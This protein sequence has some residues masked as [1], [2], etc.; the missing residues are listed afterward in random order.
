MNESKTLGSSVVDASHYASTLE[1][2]VHLHGGKD[3]NA[4]SYLIAEMALGRVD[5][6]ERFYAS[7]A[8]Y[9][10]NA[11]LR[12][13]RDRA[14][15]EEVM[16]T[17]L[18]QVWRQSRRFDP[19]KGSASNWLHCMLHSRAIDAMRSASPF[20]LHPDSRNLL[21]NHPDWHFDPQVCLLQN[22]SFAQLREALHALVPEQQEVLNLAF[23]QDLTH[24]EIAARLSVP[25]GTV[26]SRIRRG[27]IR[28]R[29]LLEGKAER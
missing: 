4:S 6:L 15:A 10:K 9:L 26:K 14:L 21:E 7:N 1:R 17:T 5:A 27:L 28:L 18:W 11:A 23:F 22:E 2:P 29:H 24:E 19:A 8:G 13:T 20:L 3:L 12:I 16:A 25:L